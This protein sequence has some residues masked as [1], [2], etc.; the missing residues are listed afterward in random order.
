M[1]WH[2]ESTWAALSSFEVL[3]SYVVHI[4]FQF[5]FPETRWWGKS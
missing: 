2:L 1:F 4:F 5:S 3:D